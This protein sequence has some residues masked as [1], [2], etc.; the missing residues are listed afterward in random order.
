MSNLSIVE[1]LV[2]AAYKFCE[3]GKESFMIED[4]V[5]KAWKEYP[6]SFGLK[7]YFGKDKKLFYPDSNRVYAEVMGRK[8]IRNRGLIEKIGIKTY[9]LT[10]SGRTL[11]KLLLTRKDEISKVKSTLPR[12]INDFILKLLNSRAMSKLKNGKFDDISFFDACNFWGITVG[13]YAIELIVKLK[14]IEQNI[15][16]TKDIIKQDTFTIEHGGRGKSFSLKDLE[17]INKLNKLLK[18]KFESEL[19]M[20][21][22][23]TDERKRS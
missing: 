13:S 8:P 3:N 9:K 2:I 11:A 20:I 6:D 7:G 14:G 12:D 15:A 21:K 5:V 22:N 17:L 23:R 16:F 18:E 10:D 1:K 4:L 19:A